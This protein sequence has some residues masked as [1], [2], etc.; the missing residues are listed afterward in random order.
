MNDVKAVKK[1]VLATSKQWIA[2]FN[3]G[4]INGCADAYRPNAVMDARPVGQFIGRKAI[5]DF[6]Q[7]FVQSTGATDL[8]Y[9]DVS[10]E[11]LDEHNAVLSAN[12]QMNVGR[13]YISRELWQRQ[14]S[15]QWLLGEDDFTV[16]E[17][18]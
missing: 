1:Q 4:D 14:E 16:V 6:W 5:L 2:S 8:V 7:Q 12:W 15:G 18:F 10:I 13:G 11:V 3:N 17:Q 9:K